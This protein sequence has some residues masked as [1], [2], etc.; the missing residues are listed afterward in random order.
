MPVVLGRRFGVALFLQKAAA[1]CQR[2]HGV[3]AH[4]ASRRLIGSR[5]W[6][7]EHR[8]RRSAAF[9]LCIGAM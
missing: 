3:V 9:R 6:R 2:L 1:L 5:G 4:A 7:L 8:A